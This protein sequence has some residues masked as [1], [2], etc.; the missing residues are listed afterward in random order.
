MSP[1]SGAASGW[2]PVGWV[3]ASGWVRRG[4][5]GKLSVPAGTVGL[6]EEGCLCGHAAS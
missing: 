6:I 2:V 3:R 5:G 1:G 4:W